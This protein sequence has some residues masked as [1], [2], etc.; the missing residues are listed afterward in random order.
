[1]SQEILQLVRANM[2]QLNAV[3]WD[4]DAAAMGM[5][6]EGRLYP[7][8]EWPGPEVYNGRSGWAASIRERTSA[9]DRLRGDIDRLIDAGDRVIV[10]LRMSGTSRASGVEVEWPLGYIA[11]DFADGRPRELR[12]FISQEQAIATAGI[13]PSS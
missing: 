3:G 11:S 6:P 2:E 4:T 7:P 8:A 12:W 1:M 10:L 9:F 13:S 5:H